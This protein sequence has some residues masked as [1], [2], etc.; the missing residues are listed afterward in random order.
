MYVEINPASGVPIYLQ[1]KNQVK[2]MIANSMLK[3]DEMLPSVR[4]LALDIRVN[5]N[6]IAKAYRELELEGVLYTKRGTGVF[7]SDKK[8]SLSKLKKEEK[9]KALSKT[10]DQ[11]VVEAYHYGVNNEELMELLLTRFKKYNEVLK[12]GKNE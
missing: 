5:P 1:L 4:Q 6:T 11:L 10:M 3:P 8:R 9:I 12:G 7:V 2:N